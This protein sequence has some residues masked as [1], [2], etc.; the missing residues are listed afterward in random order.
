MIQEFL[1]YFVRFIVLN[2]Y[3][4]NVYFKNFSTTDIYEVEKNE[5]MHHK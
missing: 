1:E 4:N 2:T 5:Q 3:K